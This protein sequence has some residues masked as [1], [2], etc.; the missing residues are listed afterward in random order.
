MG[1]TRSAMQSESRNESM[2]PSA[3]VL[4]GQ[5]EFDRREISCNICK[6]SHDN[7]WED[8]CLQGVFQKRNKSQQ[9]SKPK[10]RTHS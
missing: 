1:I 9:V 5:C 8:I 2:V 6:S 10:V 4:T 3:E 7:A